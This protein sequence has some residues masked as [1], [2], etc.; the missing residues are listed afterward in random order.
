MDKSF[1]P[2]MCRLEFESLVP[3]EARWIQMQHVVINPCAPTGERGVDIYRNKT[4]RYGVLHW[5]TALTSLLL[6]GSC[7]FLF[8][9]CWGDHSVIPSF[10]CISSS[11][12]HV[13]LW[14]FWE[15]VIKILSSWWRIETLQFFQHFSSELTLYSNL[16][17]LSVC[18]IIYISVFNIKTPI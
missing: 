6:I 2:Q 11:L 13:Y 10:L 5:R 18:L 17:K 8:L 4:G 3:Y 14:L 15:Q 9:Q 7:I 12:S 1:S 16:T